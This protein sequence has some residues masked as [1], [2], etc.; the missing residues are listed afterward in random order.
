[1]MIDL[2]ELDDWNVHAVGVMGDYVV[3][4]QLGLKLTKQSA[5][6]FAIWTLAMVCPEA[7]SEAALAKVSA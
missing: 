1:M 4:V 3:S 2:K 7:L 5:V 6:Q